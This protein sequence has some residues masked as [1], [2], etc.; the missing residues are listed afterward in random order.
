MHML[1]TYVHDYT[2]YTVSQTMT[3]LTPTMIMMQDDGAWLHKALWLI[4]QK[5]QK[6]RLE[7]VSVESSITDEPLITFKI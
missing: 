4:N 1:G 7:E 5:H 3:T 6:L 2:K